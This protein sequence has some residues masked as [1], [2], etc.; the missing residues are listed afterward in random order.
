MWYQHGSISSS[1]MA[2]IGTK[3]RTKNEINNSPIIPR[4]AYK[5]KIT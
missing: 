1:Q 2:Y 5:Y 4:H 3:S